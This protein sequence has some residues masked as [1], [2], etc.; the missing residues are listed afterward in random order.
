MTEKKH[1]D[2]TGVILAGGHSM[3]MGEDKGHKLHNGIPFTQH[4]IDVLKTITDTIIIITDDPSYDQYGY[5]CVP[6]HIPDQGPVGGIY[7]ALKHSKTEKNLILSCDIPFITSNILDYLISQY[8][9][10]YDVITYDDT[11]LIGVYHKAT[12]AVFLKSIKTKKLSLI[13]TISSLRLKSIP[14]EKHMIPYLKNI[15]TQQQ[16]KE[17][18]Q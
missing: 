9:I 6:D 16:Y 18:T 2:I 4:I 13:K 10:I 7:T 8:E 17:A 1:T 11:P 3:R 14:I 15:N 12:L 5:S